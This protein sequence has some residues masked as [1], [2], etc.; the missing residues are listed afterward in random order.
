VL[1]VIFGLKRIAQDGVGAVALLAIAA[2]LAV[3]VLFVRRQLRLPDPLIDLRLFRLRAFTVSLATYG[4]AILVLFGGFLF[5]PQYLQLVLGLSPLV[6][7][8]W[9]LPW[10]LA[11][12]AG[13]LLTPALTRRVRPVV[14]MSSGLVFGAIGFA[15]F[16]RIS[17]T[18]GFALFAGGSTIFSL[19]FSPVFTLT[20]DIIVGSAPPERA[21]AA[22][23]I[24]E[25]SGELG[26][27]L[28]IALFGSIGVAL[29]RSLMA[30]A[31]PPEVPPAAALEAT[32]TLGGAVAVARQ[33]PATLGGPLTE[34]ARVAFV[35]GIQVCAWIS[36][37]GAL[38][39]AGLAA[40]G[41]RK[42]GVAPPV[43]KIDRA[44][45][46]DGSAAPTS[47]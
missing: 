8:L 45:V 30:G 1:A 32:A 40:F 46:E 28:G 2:G 16:T 11:F 18:T 37:A 10:A 22:A 25:T 13:S 12:V 39:L 34:A 27:A 3:G 29:Y 35:R 5:L 26:G 31:V 41:L 36:A 20:T 9:T 44:H 4:L 17:E 7:G 47:P 15:L 43:E 42:P 19:G 33:L 24:S 21:G 23:A 38:G 6:A 14:L